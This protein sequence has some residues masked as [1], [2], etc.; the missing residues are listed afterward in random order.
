MSADAFFT[1]IIPGAGQTKPAPGITST[2]TGAGKTQ[3]PAL[4]FA[5]YIIAQLTQLQQDAQ[6]TKG[7]ETLATANEETS[8]TPAIRHSFAGAKPKA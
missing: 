6:T 5:D 3:T 8:F 4:D 1:L 7:G 2:V